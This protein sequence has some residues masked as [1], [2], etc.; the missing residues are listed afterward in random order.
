MVRDGDGVPDVERADELTPLELEAQGRFADRNANEA[1]GG[2]DHD[3]PLR[4]RLKPAAQRVNVTHA[5]GAFGRSQE[6]VEGQGADGAQG[7]RAH[8]LT[9]GVTL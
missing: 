9:S 6:G 3:V 4:H 7:E 2:G 5:L 1:A 8:G